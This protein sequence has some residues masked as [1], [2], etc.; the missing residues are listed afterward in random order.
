MNL[1]NLSLSDLNSKELW[2]S[3]L[4][5]S[6]FCWRTK[7]YG[8]NNLVDFCETAERCRVIFL[9]LY[10][11]IAKLKCLYLRKIFLSVFARSRMSVANEVR[12][13]NL[14]N[15]RINYVK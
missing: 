15:V 11:K 10:F 3:R 14:V 2:L 8:N 1:R 7:N 12:R 5:S 4:I 9:L 13:S 6:D